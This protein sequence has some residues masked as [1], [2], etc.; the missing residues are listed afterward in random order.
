MNILA[1]S[2]SLFLSTARMLLGLAAFQHVSVGTLLAAK[3]QFEWVSGGGSQVSDKTRAIAVDASGN[4][5]LAGEISGPADFGMHSVGSAGKM[6]VF[7]AKLSATGEFVWAK[8]F[9][10]SETDRAYGVVPDAEGNVYV[11]GHFQ[12][13]DMKFNGVLQPNN[14]DYDL[15]VLKLSA[16]GELLWGKTAG[17]AGYD[18]AHAVALDG[19]GDVVLTGAVAG[20]A[21]FGAISVNSGSKDRP[22]FVAKYS[23]KGD[24][25]WAKCSAG[26]SGSGH[27]IGVDAGD[28]IYVGGSFSGRG[29]FDSV[30]LHAEKGSCSFVLK[31]A[32]DG[33][34]AGAASFPGTAP[35]IH[36]IAVDRDGRVWIAGMYKQNM[37]IGTHSLTSSSATNSDGFCASLDRDLSVRWVHALH[38]EGVDYCLGVAT[39]GSGRGFFTG[40][41]TGDAVFSE[42][43][44]HGAGATDIF[45]AAFDADG[46]LE[47]VERCGS[48]KGDNAYTMAWHPSGFLVLGGACTAPAQFGQKVMNSPRG[49]EAYGAKIKVR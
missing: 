30:A 40:E 9:G 22:V 3:P 5:Y 18:Y 20:E 34:A 24:L 13:A 27:G 28:Q 6:D 12:S 36:E 17:G 32:P 31:L 4:T 47:W 25:K 2:S 29:A 45:V 37:Q 15:F 7:V 23:A 33:S 26:V 11:A 21:R 38:G 49:A 16:A 8:S 39:D 41:F 48:E 19:K 42:A 46:R 14:G 35:T 10:G 1:S 44:L 43:A